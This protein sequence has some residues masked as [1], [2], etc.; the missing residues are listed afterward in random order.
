MSNMCGEE[1]GRTQLLQSLICLRSELGAEP[2][3]LE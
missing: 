1:A 2:L 3:W